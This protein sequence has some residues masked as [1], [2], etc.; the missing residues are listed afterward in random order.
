MANQYDFDKVFQ[1]LDQMETCLDRV[2]NLNN[3]LD[4]EVGVIKKAA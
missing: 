1:V 2:R 3:K 4:E